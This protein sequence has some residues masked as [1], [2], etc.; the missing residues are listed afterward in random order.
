MGKRALLLFVLCSSLLRA[1][2]EPQVF[3]LSYPRSGNTWMRFCLEYLTKPPT[4]SFKENPADIKIYSQ[5]LGLSIRELETDLSKPCIWKV[6]SRKRIEQIAPCLPHQDKIIF[7]IRNYREC[8]LRDLRDPLRILLEL[9]NP[10]AIYFD[11]LSLYE[12]WDPKLRLMIYYEDL[13]ENPRFELQRVLLFLEEPSD[14]LEKFL[15]ELPSLKQL[16]LTFYKKNLGPTNSE[17]IDLHHHSKRISKALREEM[18]FEVMQRYPLFW[19][20]YLSHYF[21]FSF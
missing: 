19:E 17:G 2:E 7:L 10:D 13:I 16:S 1:Y 21:Y 12:K 4:C 14:L 5:P 18:D 9:K 8:L 11:N 20:R 3:L 15:I 6:H